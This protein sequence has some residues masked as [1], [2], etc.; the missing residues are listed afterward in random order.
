LIVAGDSKTFESPLQRAFEVPRFTASH[1]L[2]TG[3]G[4]FLL[5]WVLLKYSMPELLEGIDTV[6]SFLAEDLFILFKEAP[7]SEL[8]IHSRSLVLGRTS[9]LCVKGS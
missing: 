1:V 3:D 4:K 6:R 7:L 2:L 9:K 5:A 8:G